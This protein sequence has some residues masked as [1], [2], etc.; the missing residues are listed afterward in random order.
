[1]RAGPHERKRVAELRELVEYHNQRYYVLDDPEISDAE[2]DALF[3][4]LQTLEERYAALRSSDSPT[5]RVGGEPA[6]GFEQVRHE[7]PMLSLANAFSDDELADFDKR[8]RERLHAE[9]EIVYS[10]E[11]K[12]DGL[13]V[14]LRY[15]NGLLVQAA[16]RGDGTTGENITGNVRTI[17]N[18]PL[19]LQGKPPALL[20]VRGEVY[21]TRKGF[22]A[23]NEKAREAGG[24]VF[25]NPRNAA[26]GSVRQLDSR[27]TARRPLAMYC[28]AL[29][30]VSDDGLFEEHAQVLSAF[31]DW[32]LPVS[33]ETEL[34]T[35]VQGCIGYYARVGA[36]RAALPYEIDGVVFKVNSLTEQ[37]SLGSVSRAPRWAIARKFPA[38]EA[39][40]QLLDVEFQVGRTGALT[41]VARLRPVTVGGVTVSNATLHNMDEIERKDVRI[42]DSV[43]VRRAGD[44]IPEVVRTLVEERPKGA[45]MPK[46]PDAC[47][48]CGSAVVREPE[49]AV[50]RCTGGL[51]C[52]AQRK[53][54]IKHF[55]SRRALDIEGL[56]DKLV[57][58]LVEAGLV[59]HVDDIYA[60]QLEQLQ[61]LERMGEKSAQNLIDALQ[62]SKDTTL[63]RF[64]YALGIRE[65]G[66]T[67]AQTLAD[68][69]GNIDSLMQA[70]AE[71][72]LAVG[73]VGPVVAEHVQRFFAEP[74]NRE[75]IEALRAAGLHWP[76]GPP[77]E[78]QRPLTGSTYVLTGTLEAL[79]RDQAKA[80]LQALGAR[81]A[82]SVSSKTTAVIAGSSAGSKLDKAEALG[83]TVMDEAELE[84]LLQRY[85]A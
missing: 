69:F 14:S 84:S 13:A 27:I 35:G 46:M 41:P 81:V 51:F 60:L 70:D 38:E 36:I 64:V 8:I 12:L 32:G 79:T 76:E 10:A 22:A 58:Q 63:G 66:E 5:Q 15:E 39:A 33:R 45:H 24:K 82:G 6:A 65:V 4:E 74:H 1:M 30:A 55:A 77:R 29:G 80:R 83:V 44:V 54:A 85:E 73:D 78:T 7:A 19:R 31:R 56:G 53:E 67:T 68:H 11:P 37:A 59:E 17:R 50:H 75:V 62:H 21:M 49:Q 43:V 26:A 57:E 9:H 61:S 72:L 18:V 40:T 71:T 28:Y 20:E 48:V 16:T 42:G 23:I 52:G 25:A 2:Y 47:P 34:V 3:R